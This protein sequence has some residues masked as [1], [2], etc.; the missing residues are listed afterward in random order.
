MPV[1]GATR[2]W[3]ALG[4]APLGLTHQAERYLTKLAQSGL[5]STTV[6]K[7]HDALRLFLEWCA[8]RSLA[9]APELTPAVL[10]RYQRHLHELRTR[11]GRPLAVRTRFLRVDA[12]R[13]LCAFL[14]REGAVTENPAAGQA[15]LRTP[16]R[17]PRGM[18]TLD[19]VER[20]L[21]QPTI[22]T[23]DGLRDRAMLEVIFAAALRAVE[24]ASLDL[25]DFDAARGSLRI[26]AGPRRREHEVPLSERAV[27][28]LQWY[29]A[30][31]RAEWS[32]QRP[33]EP[34]L[35]IGQL[36]ARLDLG[37]LEHRLGRYAKA[38]GLSMAGVFHALRD[39]VAAGLLEGGVDARVVQELLGHTS[40][41]ST[42]RYTRVSIARLHAVH[43]RT[44]PA[45][46]R[47]RQRE[48]LAA[49]SR[50]NDAHD[51]HDAHDDDDDD[52]ES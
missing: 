30:K 7:R 11:Q 15:L 24:L 27:T 32:L 43:E 1:R 14:L 8:A 40:L 46:I 36:G 9:E 13:E 21:A 44:H 52:D 28:W 18:L 49:E 38:A 26:K 5:S 10:E 4:A 6:R 19:E 37:Y 20:L 29:L 47:R 34:A 45:E 12:V 25:D 35:F 51:A 17:L 31:T 22:E 39:T 2:P 3:P 33:E 16:K 42:M 50:D 48:A 41:R 23:L